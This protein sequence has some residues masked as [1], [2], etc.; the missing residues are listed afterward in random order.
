MDRKIAL[1]EKTHFYFRSARRGKHGV[2]FY[3]NDSTRFLWIDRLTSHDAHGSPK[4][5]GFL[6]TVVVSIFQISSVP[7]GT[8]PR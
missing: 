1:M 5:T 2:N 3:C 4:N 8:I 6:Q 7:G